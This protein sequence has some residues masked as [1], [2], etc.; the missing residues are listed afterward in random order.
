MNS[1]DQNSSIFT[2]YIHPPP[3]PPP[4]LEEFFGGDSTE[5]QDSP[6]GITHI[7]DHHQAAA[8]AYVDLKSGGFS[9]NSGSELDDS[10]QTRS[11]AES[12]ASQ[13]VGCAMTANGGGLSIEANT[14]NDSDENSKGGS[15]AIVVSKKKIAADTFGQRTSIYRGVTK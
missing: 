11:P 12:A 6:L 9:A 2:T 15:T 1:Q 5:T 10:G 7:Y 4:K 13:L 8:A 14:F 3:P